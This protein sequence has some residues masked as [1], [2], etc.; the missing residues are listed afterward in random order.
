MCAPTATRKPI[1]G[2]PAVPTGVNAFRTL[3]VAAATVTPAASSRFTGAS[4]R[5]GD[6]TSL[7]PI[8]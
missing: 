5:R 4:P 7:R 3:L 2:S 1:S 6:R 8:R